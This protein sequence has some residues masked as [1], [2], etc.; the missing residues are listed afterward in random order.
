MQ[1]KN[2]A[3]YKNMNLEPR[4]L[5]FEIG[6]VNII[7]GESSTGKTAII[8]IINYCLGSGGFHVKGAKIR[9][10]IKWFAI[11]VQ[12]PDS[13]IFIAR[14]NPTFLDLNTTSNIFFLCEDFI[15]IPKF[16]DLINNSNITALNHFISNKL[17]FHDN[18]H[19]VKNNTRDNLEATFKHS[20]LFSFQPQ[21][22]IAQHKHIFFNQDEPF[23]PQAIKD[24][25]PYVLGAIKEDELL[26]QQQIS[27][28]R[29]QLNKYISVLKKDN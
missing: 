3:L 20:R 19:L 17:N 16:N 14:Q 24:T 29:K 9:E 7:T 13:Q 25:L 15:T 10:N 27:T 4:I 6:K 21:D 22:V 2:I 23:I 11:T 12:F 5:P 8:D 1:I 28:K 18:L 26:I